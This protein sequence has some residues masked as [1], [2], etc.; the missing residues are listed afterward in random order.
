LEKPCQLFSAAAVVP[1]DCSGVHPQQ[2]GHLGDG[3]TFEF[4]QDD[5]GASLGFEMGQS[6]LDRGSGY[7]LRLRTGGLFL[8]QMVSYSW[9]PPHGETS[10]PV[11]A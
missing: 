2:V 5:D 10:V 9:P 1:A 7:G 6:R 3:Q 8:M 4:S 11:T